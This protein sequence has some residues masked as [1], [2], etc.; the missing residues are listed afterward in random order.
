L[1]SDSSVV[2]NF[3]ILG[4]GENLAS[5]SRGRIRVV[6][7]VLGLDANESGE[8]DGIAKA[9]DEEAQ[10]APGSRASTLAL[11]AHGNLESLL[12]RRDELFEVV[13]PIHDEVQL[14]LR[15]Q[16]RDERDWRAEIGMR[17]R[18]LDSGEAIS[19]AVAV[20]RKLPFASDDD[21]G[22]KAYLAL[23][24]IEFLWTCDLVKRCIEEGLLREVEARSGY[25]SLRNDHRFWGPPWD[26]C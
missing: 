20:K 17:A 18:R 13:V 24:G 8:L 5:L 12:A 25:E 16:D 4:W 7:G 1:I 15:L 14:A 11:M 3:S 2:R 21:D 10:A 22:R 23:E 19:L 9:L 6:H 26:E